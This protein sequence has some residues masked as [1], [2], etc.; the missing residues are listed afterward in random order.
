MSE[1]LK[2]VA[3]RRPP[4]LAALCNALVVLWL[5]V[6]AFPFV[7]TV[8]G[9]FKVEGDFFSRQSFWDAVSGLKTTLQTGHPFTLDGYYGAWVVNGFW[10]SVINTAIVTVCVTVISLTF[11]TL[12]GYALARSGHRYAFW[13]LIAALVFRAMPHITLVSAICCRSFSSTSG[14][15]CRP[16][17][18][19][20]SRSTS[21]LRCGC[22]IRFS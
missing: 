1:H 12:G 11:G 18:S 21:H 19:C 15:C 10:R 9:S 6:A 8:W 7:W 2:S 16:P 13:L 5:L 17:S 22:C 3:F 14:A 20:W 4:L